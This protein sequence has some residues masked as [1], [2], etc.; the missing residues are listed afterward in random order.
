[1]KAMLVLTA[2]AA[3]GS[4]SPSLAVGQQCT[5]EAGFIRRNAA[6]RQRRAEGRVTA[7]DAELAAINQCVEARTGA[8]PLTAKPF[9]NESTVNAAGQIYR[10]ESYSHYVCSGGGSVCW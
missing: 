2:C 3:P 9:V 7:S 10:T 6:A 1:M 8:T 5:D 4:R